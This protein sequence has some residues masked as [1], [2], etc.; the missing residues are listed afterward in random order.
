MAL[1]EGL[2]FA[3]LIGLVEACSA[4]AP[5]GPPASPP[6]ANA[7]AQRANPA[8]SHCVESGGRLVIEK[9]AAGGEFGVCLF[10]D[11]YQCEEWALLRGHCRAGGVRIT[12]YA[13]PAGRYCAI[14]GGRY[15]VTS[16]DDPKE[17]GSCQ[18]QDGRTC[19]A[20]AF[21]NASCGR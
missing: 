6:A 7:T 16:G 2:L 1:K 12:G 5:P 10:E 4:P 3:L 19:D 15:T 17:R 20:E 14:T 8:S 18:L 9:D 11:N 13:T 21:F